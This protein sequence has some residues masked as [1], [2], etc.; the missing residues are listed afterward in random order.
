[1]PGQAWS[2]NGR[3][4][5][6]SPFCSAVFLDM[7]GVN[8]GAQLIPPA[9]LG[10]PRT[11]RV[12]TANLGRSWK[13]CGAQKNT[14]QNKTHIIRIIAEEPKRVKMRPW[15]NRRGAE[16]TSKPS[17][18]HGLSPVYTCPSGLAPNKLNMNARNKT[19]YLDKT[20]KKHSQIGMLRPMTNS[21]RCLFL[22]NLR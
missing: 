8:S 12:V 18:K 17:R 22:Y 6:S 7:S 20:Q 2:R 14:Q 3:Y 16:G 9:T 21:L 13:I 4:L 15:R 5:T 1:M 11:A 19:G 10:H